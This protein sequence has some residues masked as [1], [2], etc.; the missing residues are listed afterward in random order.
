MTEQALR[1][2]VLPLLVDPLGPIDP[3][4][5]SELDSDELLLLHL[6]RSPRPSKLRC[7]SPYLLSPSKKQRGQL[8]PFQCQH[9]LNPIRSRCRWHLLPPC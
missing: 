8:N 7:Q 2:H 5:A 1:K 4:A 3:A 9:L 6:L